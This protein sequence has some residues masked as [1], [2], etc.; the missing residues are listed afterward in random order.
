MLVFKKQFRTF[1]KSK[2]IHVGIRGWK[3]KN[4]AKQIGITKL[5]KL[6]IHK[7]IPTISKSYLTLQ[8]TTL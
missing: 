8:N 5:T 4:T 6:D 7:F 1:R 2:N 3:L